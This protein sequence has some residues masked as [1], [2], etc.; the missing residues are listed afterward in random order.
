MEKLAL[1]SVLALMAPATRLFAST[2]LTADQF[3]IVFPPV[4]QGQASSP[5]LARH[6]QPY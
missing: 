1:F 6:T 5:P 3:Q 2:G 4:V